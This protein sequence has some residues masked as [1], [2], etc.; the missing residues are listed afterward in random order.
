MQSRFIEN[1][2]KIMSFLH[3]TTATDQSKINFQIDLKISLC[4]RENLVGEECKNINQ[5][6]ALGGGR[7]CQPQNG[8]QGRCL[9]QNHLLGTL[10]RGIFWSGSCPVTDSLYGE[11]TKEKTKARFL[12]LIGIV[13]P[14]QRSLNFC[15]IFVLDCFGGF[16]S[17]KNNLKERF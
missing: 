16:I 1:N 6:N 7:R 3:L 13:G 10:S 2:D 9:L 4:K 5:G 12:F 17:L 15:K 14:A 11:S 8:P